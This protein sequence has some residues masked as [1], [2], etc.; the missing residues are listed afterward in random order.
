MSSIFII[1]PCLCEQNNGLPKDVYFLILRTCDMFCY[2]VHSFAKAAV[3]KYHRLD[4]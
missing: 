4:A 3:T 2:M 1:S